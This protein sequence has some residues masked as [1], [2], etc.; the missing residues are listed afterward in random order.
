MDGLERIDGKDGMDQI[1]GMDGMDALPSLVLPSLALPSLQLP[2]LQL[3]PIS[4]HTTILYP[5]WIT[6]VA[7]PLS[8]VVIQIGYF[9]VL[10]VDNYLDTR[11]GMFAD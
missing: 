1:D 10:S 5:N 6:T 9:G 2:A 7:P 8:R 3:P 11:L 4:P